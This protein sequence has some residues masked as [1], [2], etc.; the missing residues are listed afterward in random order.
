CP[1]ARGV[2]RTD[3]EELKTAVEA[4]VGRL[5][6]RGDSYRKAIVGWGA[7]PVG[8]GAGGRPVTLHRPAGLQRRTGSRYPGTAL[9]R[10]GRAAGQ[11]TPADSSRSDQPK[12]A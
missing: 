2:G 5:E 9:P 6:D 1:A 11:T 8:G 3:A 10:G 4:L 7:G 12:G